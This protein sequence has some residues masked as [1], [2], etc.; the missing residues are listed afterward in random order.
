MTEVASSTA[1]H[2][3]SIAIAASLAVPM[4]ASRMTG[5]A[6]RLD[7]QLDVVLVADAEAGADRGAERHD[8]G[9]PGLLQPPGQDGVITGVGQD[10]EAVRDQLIGGGEQLDR[11]RQQ[12]P[13]IR[14]DLQLDPAGAERFP[15]Q[16]GHPHRLG[17]P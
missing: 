14:D 9:A 17:R 15:C 2:P 13:L 11:I 10:G 8:R 6:C 3:S 12:R 5:N 4:P 16:P 7:D 1:A